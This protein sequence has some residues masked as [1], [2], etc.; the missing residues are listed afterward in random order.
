MAGAAALAKQFKF[1]GCLVRLSRPAQLGVGLDL[2]DHGGK[3]GVKP[4]K[5]KSGVEFRYSGNSDIDGFF[6]RE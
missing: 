6:G 2:A 3:T 1:A 5:R 4:R